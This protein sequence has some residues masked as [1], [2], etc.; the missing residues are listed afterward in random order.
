MEVEARRTAT[1]NL[2]QG[3]YYWGYDQN[4]GPP[5]CEA[6]MPKLCHEIGHVWQS[7]VNPNKYSACRM[8]QIP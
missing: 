6:R 5:R 7:L 2:S 8:C 3:R 4:Q 1:T